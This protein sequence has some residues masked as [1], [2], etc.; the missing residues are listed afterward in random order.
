[1]TNAFPNAKNAEVLFLKLRRSA[2][3]GILFWAC[4]LFKMKKGAERQVIKTNRTAPKF[5]V[6]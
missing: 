1:M 4:A 6:K 2:L 3:S 5:L